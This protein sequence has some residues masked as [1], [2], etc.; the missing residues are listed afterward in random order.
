[1]F[2]LPSGTRVHQF[3]RGSYPVTIHS[4]AFSVD[5]S[6]LAVSS[7][8]DTIHIFKLEDPAAAATAY[9]RAS[10]RWTLHVDMV[11]EN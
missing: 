9:A 1:M 3:R 4:L 5:S 7:E 2:T 6:I 8:S 11:A 10:R